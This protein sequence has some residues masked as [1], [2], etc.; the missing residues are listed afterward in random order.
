MGLYS[1]CV[2]SAGSSKSYEFS[3]P[4]DRRLVP[5]LFW[6]GPPKGVTLAPEAA[7]SLL[8]VVLTW[9]QSEPRLSIRLYFATLVE[10]CMQN[11]FIH[12]GTLSVA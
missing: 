3:M 9:V 12:L 10:A 5:M 6:V 8:T 11:L 1:S 2:L 4:I 7:S